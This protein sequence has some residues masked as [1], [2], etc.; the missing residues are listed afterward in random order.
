[1]EPPPSGP[2]FLGPIL[3]LRTRNIV[4]RVCASCDKKLDKESTISVCGAPFFCDAEGC[5]RRREAAGKYLMPVRC[6]AVNSRTHL[7]GKITF[8][9][10]TEVIKAVAF[11]GVVIDLIGIEA[12]EYDQLV[13][14]HPHLSSL[15]ELHLLSLV[16]HVTLSPSEKEKPADPN[17]SQD[18]FI[19]LLDPCCDGRREGYVKFVELPSVQP[20]VRVLRAK[21]AIGIDGKE[22]KH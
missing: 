18:A 22:R 14:Y 7:K 12:T 16:C 5:R 4:R 6:F 2:S 19:D 21:N 13:H 8:A 1:M 20:L 15:L 17:L 9:N 10:G 11:D 3:T